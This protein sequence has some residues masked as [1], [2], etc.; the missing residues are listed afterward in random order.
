MIV[1]RKTGCEQDS[2]SEGVRVSTSTAA[3]S[4]STAT[5]HAQNELY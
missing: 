3:A 4:N 5:A 2:P 1:A